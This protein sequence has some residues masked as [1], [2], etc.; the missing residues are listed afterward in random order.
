LRLLNG[1][2]F[3]R[4]GLSVPEH[5]MTQLSIAKAGI[6]EVFLYNLRESIRAMML[7]RDDPLATRLPGLHPLH[8]LHPLNPIHPGLHPPLPGTVRGLYDPRYMYKYNMLNP[9]DPLYKYADLDLHFYRKQILQDQARLGLK[10]GS[11]KTNR[12]NSKVPNSKSPGPGYA[13]NNTLPPLLTNRAA[14]NMSKIE[15]EEK[16][17]EI[18]VREEELETLRAKL[19]RLEHLVGLKDARIQ[20]LSTQIDKLKPGKRGSMVPPTTTKSDSKTPVKNEN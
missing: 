5:I 13:D 15:I 17:Q 16:N 9:T 4:L 6:I 10:S 12:K 11:L 14:N 18:L 3:I 1:K 20:D 8:A 7:Y 19:K 2:V